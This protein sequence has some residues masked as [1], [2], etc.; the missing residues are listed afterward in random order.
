MREI[1]I[2]GRNISLKQ[3]TKAQLKGLTVGDSL[4]YK[5]YDGEYR[6]VSLLF[7]E[8]KGEKPSPRTCSI[9]SSRMEDL[10]GIPVVF[11]FPAIPTY[12]RQRLI[13]KDV[14][15]VAS[16]KF[17]NLPM[18]VANERLRKKP[19]ARKL[20]PAAQYILLYH[21]Q[22]ES[23][24]GLAARDMVDKF[25]YSYETITLAL[26]CLSDLTLCKK[27]ADGSKRKIIRF[28][29]KGRELWDKAQDFVI[30]P[31]D[32]RV[33]CDRFECEDEYPICGINALAHYSR[34][35]PDPERMLLMGSKQFKELDAKGTFVNINDYDGDIII[36]SWK[37]PVVCNI[38]TTPQWADILS[39]AISLKEDDD[40]RVEGEV[41]RIINEMEWKD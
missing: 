18:L 31:V 15:F 27:V 13:D 38:G 11:I 28:E 8:C 16:E 20:T 7:V 24:E 25:L 2:L 23:L 9:T 41:E 32:Q 1:S 19:I 17:A 12:E 26:T 34:L 36:E 10:F 5:F 30:N 37:Y 21:L 29:H 33:Y 14:F 6:G 39:L 22:V 4:S 40:P 35:N 3:R